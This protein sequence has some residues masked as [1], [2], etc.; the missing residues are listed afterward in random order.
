MGS[1]GGVPSH[2]GGLGRELCPSRVFL[3]FGLKLASFCST[4]FCVQVKGMHR[5]MPPL[6]M[7]LELR[8]T[9][10]LGSRSTT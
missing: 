4:N 9:S 3:I 6:N 2:W 8:L 7:P 5:P 10:F 1:G